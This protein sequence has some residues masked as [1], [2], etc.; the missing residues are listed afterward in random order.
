[1]RARPLDTCDFNKSAPKGSDRLFVECGLPAV[2]WFIMPNALAQG[3]LPRCASCA[4]KLMKK[5]NDCHYLAR[6]LN[7]HQEITREEAEV[8]HVFDQ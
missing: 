1:M 8:R 4:K 3:V 6:N 2:R 5:Q 7:F